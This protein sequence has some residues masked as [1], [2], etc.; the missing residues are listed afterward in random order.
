MRMLY[1]V[2]ILIREGVVVAS[3]GVVYGLL[4]EASVVC[5]RCDKRKQL[6][7]RTI[8]NTVR[9]LLLLPLLVLVVYWSLMSC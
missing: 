9:L 3:C 6:K 5:S 4:L 8:P 1:T 7:Q 2:L